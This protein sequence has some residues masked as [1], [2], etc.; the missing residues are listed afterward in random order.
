MVALFLFAHPVTTAAPITR[1]L[2]SKEEMVAYATEQALKAQVSPS[3]VLYVISCESGWNPTAVGDGGSSHGLV[4]IHEPSH[5]D[6]SR[7]TAQDPRWAI[8][9]LVSELKQ[10]NGRQWTCYRNRPQ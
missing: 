3:A 7:E 1:E 2:S 4:Q 10:G 8:N 9:Y 5:P 6:I